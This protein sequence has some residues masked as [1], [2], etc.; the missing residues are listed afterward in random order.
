MLLILYSNNLFIY[1]N[2]YILAVTDG[3]GSCKHSHLAS[4]F[5]TEK[6]VN[7]LDPSEL[8]EKTNKIIFKFKV[9][10]GNS[11]NPEMNSYLQ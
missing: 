8:L 5:I 9:F 1:D 10:E 3:A 4:K 7:N 2:K 6:L 11:I